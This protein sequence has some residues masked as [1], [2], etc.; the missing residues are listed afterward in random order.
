MFLP[1]MLFELGSGSPDFQYLS[2]NE[3]V[4]L[5]LSVKTRDALEGLESE[6]DQDRVDLVKLNFLI[7]TR[8][9]PWLVERLLVRT[10]YLN[11]DNCNSGVVHSTPH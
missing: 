6:E 9:Y 4:P 10:L 1:L 8:P 7:G 2:V 11:N 3:S 5:P